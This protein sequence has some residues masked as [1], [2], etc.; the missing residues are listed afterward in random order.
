MYNLSFIAAELFSHGSSTGRSS[1]FGSKAVS[2]TY[3]ILSKR[4]AG[5]SRGHPRLES[6]IVKTRFIKI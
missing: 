1:L 5:T 4:D 3:Q 2:L 6:K